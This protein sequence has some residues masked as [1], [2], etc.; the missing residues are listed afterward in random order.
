MLGH[1]VLAEFSHAAK[2][3]DAAATPLKTDE[4]A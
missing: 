2:N 4:G 1:C 3:R